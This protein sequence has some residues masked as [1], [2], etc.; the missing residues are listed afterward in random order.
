MPS[1]TLVLVHGAWHGA[2]C[3][4]EL[5][6]ELERRGVAWRAIDLAS[7]HTAS[8][9]ETDLN[10]DVADVVA[11][12]RELDSVILVGHS[13]G[14]AVVSEA[15]GRLDNVARVVFLCALVPALGESASNAAR[16]VRVRTL[17]DEAMLV[18]DGFITLEPALVGAALYQEC[19]ESDR[20]WALAHLGEQTLASF[21]TVR[22]TPDTDVSRRYIL[23]ANDRALDPAL[24]RVMAERCDE[25]ITLASDH[26]PFLSHPSACADAILA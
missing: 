17:L 3:W 18:N 11:L 22:E 16:A 24:Q 8:R 14:G 12:C 13:Y 5:G 1:P 7:S 20:A 4:R 23:C 15:A 6:L 19:S 21:R 26:S 10:D 9:P 25:T 2:W